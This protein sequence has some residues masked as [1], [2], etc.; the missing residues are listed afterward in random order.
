MLFTAASHG[1]GGAFRPLS[2]RPS[3][4]SERDEA[5]HSRAAA[6]VAA[7]GA[8]SNA[9]PTRGHG[10]ALPA[11]GGARLRAAAAGGDTAQVQS[12]LDEGVPVDSLDTDGDSALMKA[13]HAD[14]T[15]TAALLVRRGASLDRRNRT[16]ESARDMAAAK[17][18][19]T[20]SRALRLAP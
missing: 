8:A 12:L 5:A 15:A 6:S 1:G 18:D 11:D 10:R 20:L 19:P 14:Q 13:I 7:L 4:A 9:P 16:G 3:G 17:D 2:S